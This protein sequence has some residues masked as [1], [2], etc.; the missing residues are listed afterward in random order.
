MFFT[1]LM[2]LIRFWMQKV[3]KTFFK[4]HISYLKNFISLFSCFADAYQQWRVDQRAYKPD[5]RGIEQQHAALA[6]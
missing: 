4:L 2:S 1:S 6:E 3:Q 5:F